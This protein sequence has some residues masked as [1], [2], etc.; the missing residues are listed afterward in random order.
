MAKEKYDDL[1][2]VAGE[3]VTVELGGKNWELSPPTIGDMAAMFKFVKEIKKKEERERLTE[4]IQ[5]AKEVGMSQEDQSKIVGSL[6][7]S[8]VK[9]GSAEVIEQMDSPE[10]T[11]FLL[12]RC[13][14]RNHPKITMEDVGNLVSMKNLLTIKKVLVELMFGTESLV[15]AP[16]DG[17]KKEE[18][19]GKPENPPENP[20]A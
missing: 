17:I 7:S 16:Q 20:K 11:Q 8:E 14:K 3:S 15:D 13:L 9:T 4:C 19:T 10:N 18:E 5:I 6:F 1:I 2:Q 12:W